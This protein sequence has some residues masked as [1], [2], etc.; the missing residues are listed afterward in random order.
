MLRESLTQPEDGEPLNCEQRCGQLR[1]HVTWKH[2]VLSLR[3]W[4]EELRKSLVP[5]GLGTGK[6]VF[7]HIY[8]LKGLNK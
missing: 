2:E 7:R 3:E 5:A 1:L 8:S 4:Q 6:I